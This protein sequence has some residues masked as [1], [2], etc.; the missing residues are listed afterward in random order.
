[1]LLSLVACCVLQITSL[2]SELKTY[3]E[4]AQQLMNTVPN[5]GY[6][7]AL[8]DRPSEVQKVQKRQIAFNS[9][10]DNSVSRHTHT[11]H[12]HTHTHTHTHAH[13]HTHTRARL[14]VLILN[15]ECTLD[16]HFPFHIPGP[17]SRHQS[18]EGCQ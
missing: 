8:E 9:A 10:E 3:D 2:I 4:V 5:P 18:W 15:P 7:V 1:M 14:P 12:S 16:Y 17:A 13:T 11:T 6:Y